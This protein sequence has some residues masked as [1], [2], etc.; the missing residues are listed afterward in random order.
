MENK[1]Q[2]I[3]AILKGLTLK[4]FKEIIKKVEK[5]VYESIRIN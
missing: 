4:E 5:E 3:I 2:E 1:T